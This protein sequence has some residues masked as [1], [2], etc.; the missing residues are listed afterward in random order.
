MAK[1][2]R[3]IK[4]SKN[5]YKKRKRGGRRALEVAAMLAA[6]GAL[7]FIGFAVVPPVISFITG[8]RVAAEDSAEH[9]PP[10]GNQSGNGQVAVD[11]GVTDEP[12]N[13]PEVLPHFNAIYAPSSTLDNASSL[14]G[15]IGRAESNGFD[16]V[17]LDMKD[18]TGH[19]WYASTYEPV[20]NTEIIREGALTAEQII[21]AFEGTGIKPVARLNVTLDSLAPRHL[22]NASYTLAGT[23]SKWAD[24]RLDAG[25]KF[26]LNPF[27]DGSRAYIA[28]LVG[29]L[30]DAGFN[31]II[32]ANTIFP[33]F[34]PY[35]LTILDER[36]FSMGT[37]TEGLHGL[38]AAAQEHSGSA[39]LILEMSLR[40]IVE[41][42]AGLNHTAE[43]LRMRRSLDDGITIMPVFFRDDFG[44]ELKVG[45]S[46]SV[47]LPGDI[48]GLVVMLFRQAA[49][50]TG[51]HEIIPAFVRAGLSED[52]RAEVLRAFNELEF[53]S[54]SIR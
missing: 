51:D 26:W 11:T 1:Y 54:F 34:N 7:V 43:I 30:S 37:R 17:I 29:E 44:T 39:R 18:I 25:G 14:A 19:L 33:L 32:L 10:G 15:Y 49:I 28:Y 35:D 4:R 53:D 20:R 5:L 41:N 2:G 42:Y 13:V 52:E 21:A 22:D 23:N 27:L 16:A 8:D 9:S 3:K 6:V 38:I 45:E 46:S 40:D 24:N 12:D 48:Y 31:D 50:Q 36:Y 47:V